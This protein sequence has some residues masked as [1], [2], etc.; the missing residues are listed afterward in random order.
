MIHA[1]DSPEAQRALDG[2]TPLHM[3]TDNG[4]PAVISALVAAGVDLEARTE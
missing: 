2:L 1:A 3:A 4:H